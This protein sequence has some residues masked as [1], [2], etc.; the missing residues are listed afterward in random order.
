MTSLDRI[1]QSYSEDI[2][3]LQDREI[4]AKNR[5]AGIPRYNAIVRQFVDGTYTL[6]EFRNA[7]KT[8][9][10]DT[11]WG[12]HKTFLKELNKLAKNHVPASPDVETKFRVILHNLN[13]QNVGQ[14]IEQFYN[15]LTQ[16]KNS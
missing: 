9:H 16:E 14:K 15:L 6:D 1:A 3:F 10:Q 11:Y 8:L 5:K 7:L 2:Q 4:I 13:A 12:A